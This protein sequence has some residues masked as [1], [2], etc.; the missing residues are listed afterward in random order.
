MI[1]NDPYNA[2]YCDGFEAAMTDNHKRGFHK[3]VALWIDGCPECRAL[4]KKMEYQERRRHLWGEHDKGFH[5]LRN[6]PECGQCEA[7]TPWEREQID[8]AAQRQKSEAQS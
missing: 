7:R 6:V 2:G 8:E 3:N 4:K 5:T 1:L